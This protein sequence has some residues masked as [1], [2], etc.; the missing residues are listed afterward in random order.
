M[1]NYYTD[2]LVLITGGSSGMGLS[3]A[4]QLAEQGASVFILARRQELL[5]SSIAEIKK[6]K[7]SEQQKFG[8]IQA[9]VSDYK[10]LIEKI[11]PFIAE[12][13]APDV[14]INSAGVVR[15]GEFLEQDAEYFRWQMEINYLGTVYITKL[16]APGMAKRRSGHIINLCSMA[17]F[18]GAY[19]YTAYTGTKFAIAGF[20]EALRY[21]MKVHNVRISIVYPSD[22]RTP[23]L[24]E[25]NKYKPALTKA[26]VEGNTKLMD[27]DDVARIILKDASNGR[28]T[29]TPGL[30]VTLWYIAKHLTVDLSLNV[31]DLLVGQAKKKVDLQKK[32]LES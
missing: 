28:Y 26:L 27:P 24:D 12:Y 17:G 8:V 16:I 18:V 1:K 23:Q 31:M 25:D 14:L 9:D 15:P 3:M 10:Q 19:G 6:H 5:D 20:T 32:T 2:K 30:D 4:K 21:E 13:G 7:V 29:I 11:N 22:V